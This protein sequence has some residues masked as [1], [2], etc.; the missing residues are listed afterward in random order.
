LGSIKE[1]QEHSDMESKKKENEEE[2]NGVLR[3]V[4]K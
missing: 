1:E 4:K 2:L 3:H